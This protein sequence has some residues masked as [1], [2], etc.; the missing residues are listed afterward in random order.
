MPEKRMD[1]KVELVA[2]DHCQSVKAISYCLA[3]KVELL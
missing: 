3:S 2:V 1:L